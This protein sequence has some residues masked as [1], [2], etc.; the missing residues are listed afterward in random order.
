MNEPVQ[1]DDPAAVMVDAFA[2]QQNKNEHVEVLKELFNPA[3]LRMITE[4]TDAEIAICTRMELIAKLM[5]AS[6]YADAAEMF[7][8]LRLSRQRKS[9]HEIIEAVKALFQPG[10]MGMQQPSGG[11]KSWFGGG[12]YRRLP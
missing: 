8:M 3:K 4:L 5:N 6:E 9:R 7:M 2:R 10:T 11:L 12:A 1:H